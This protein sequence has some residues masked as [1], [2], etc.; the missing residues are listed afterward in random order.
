MFVA[1]SLNIVWRF[2]NDVEFYIISQAEPRCIVYTNLNLLQI[3]ECLYENWNG[4]GYVKV[5]LIKLRLPWPG[6]FWLQNIKVF[7]NKII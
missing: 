4:L 1:N 2:N 7:V 5:I 3:P 6:M